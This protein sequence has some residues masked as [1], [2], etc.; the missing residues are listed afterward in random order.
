MAGEV[1][2]A[3][4]IYIPSIVVGELYYGAEYSTRV[5]QNRSNISKLVLSYPVLL[6]DENTGKYYG[7]VKASLRRKGQPIPENDIWIAAI[8]LQ[9]N[10]TLVTRDAHFNAINE[11]AAIA[12]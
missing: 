8:A 6:V 1:D 10:L 2:K 12:W 11:L 4:T 5:E 7:S 3:E 9:Y